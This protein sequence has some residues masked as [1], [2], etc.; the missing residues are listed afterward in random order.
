MI[1]AYIDYS[2]IVSMSVTLTKLPGVFESTALSFEAAISVLEVLAQGRDRIYVSDSDES[3]SDGL[4]EREDYPLYDNW[5]DTVQTVKAGGSIYIQ[6]TTGIFAKESTGFI[7]PIENSDISTLKKVKRKAS[8][9]Y[10]KDALDNLDF[11]LAMLPECADPVDQSEK[12]SES[13]LSS[14]SDSGDELSNAGSEDGESAQSSD[15]G[16]SIQNSVESSDFAS[17]LAESSADEETMDRKTFESIY[18]YCVRNSLKLGKLSDQ[19]KKHIAKHLKPKGI[20]LTEVDYAD[21]NAKSLFDVYASVSRAGK[22]KA[23]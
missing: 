10:D 8:I 22:K 14:E 11:L 18:L 7:V 21:S 15:T 16:D 12:V 4:E 1:L 20:T 3:G 9:P 6:G 13:A 17:S 5:V 19:D 2:V 23:R